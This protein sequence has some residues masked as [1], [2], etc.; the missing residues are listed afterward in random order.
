VMRE[1]LLHL[2]LNSFKVPVGATARGRNHNVLTRPPINPGEGSS[3]M[4][5]LKQWS[6]QN[7]PTLASD[8][9]KSCS[10]ACQWHQRKLIHGLALL[11][12]LLA[13]PFGAEAQDRKVYPGTM[14]VQLGTPST[15]FYGGFAQVAHPLR[16]AD[17]RP[18]NPNFNPQLCID[19]IVNCP[20]V[21]DEALQSYLSAHVVVQDFNEGRNIECIFGL[22]PADVISVF[23][24]APT[25][26]LPGGF[27]S[28][29]L[30]IL[31]FGPP[32]EQN[33][34]G[35]YFIR[36]FMPPGTSVFSY[37]IRERWP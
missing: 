7:T 25:N 34:G 10:R 14:C 8:Q 3:I 21:R 4:P 1:S 17:C 29:D 23:G 35:P 18:T 37:G 15:V 19:V 36:C 27:I 33:P 13:G 28:S 11:M 2:C 6:M 26:P 32:T 20:I 12:L 5:T 9:Q 24:D 22:T 30:R 16:E 31:T